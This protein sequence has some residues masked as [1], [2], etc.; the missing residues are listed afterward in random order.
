M[1]QADRVVLQKMI[2]YCDDISDLMDRFGKSYESYA[3]DIAYQYAAAMCV[4]QI[5]ELVS[6]LSD[7]AKEATKQ[8]PWRLISI[9]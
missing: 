5:G 2:G 7:E 3:T 4:L 9:C 8:I 1:K 6:R